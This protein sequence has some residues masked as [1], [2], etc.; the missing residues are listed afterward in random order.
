MTQLI[1]RQSGGAN[2]LSIPKAILKALNL[3]TGSPLELS[4]EDHKMVLTPVANQPTLQTLL[5]GSPKKNLAIKEEDHQ[6]LN[7]KSVGGEE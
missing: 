5:S 7:A 4:I 2:I 3:H 6:W 1:I